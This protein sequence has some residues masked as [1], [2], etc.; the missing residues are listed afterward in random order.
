MQWDIK[1]VFT[2]LIKE[3][4]QIYCFLLSWFILNVLSIQ[5]IP[6]VK[7]CSFKQVSLLTQYVNNTSASGES[8]IN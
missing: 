3:I 2:D 6:H 1:P 5:L 4:W 7:L 8:S